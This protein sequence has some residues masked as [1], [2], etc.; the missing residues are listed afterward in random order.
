MPT[1]EEWGAKVRGAVDPLG[2]VSEEGLHQE[3]VRTLLN[4]RTLHWN[5]ISGDIIGQADLMVNVLYDRCSNGVLDEV[6]LAPEERLPEKLREAVFQLNE[7]VGG[8][9][10]TA[11]FAQQGGGFAPLLEKLVAYVRTH[12]F[13]PSN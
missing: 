12:P 11:H 6:F 1:A 9:A 5:R 8:R 4:E 2:A 7:A 3:L 13:T 10:S